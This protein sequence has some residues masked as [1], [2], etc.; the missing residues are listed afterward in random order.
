MFYIKKHV[1]CVQIIRFFNIEQTFD[2]FTLIFWISICYSPRCPECNSI[3]YIHPKFPHLEDEI[4]KMATAER[5]FRIFHTYIHD[6]QNI[7]RQYHDAIHENEEQV[8]I[9]DSDRN[10]DQEIDK[11]RANDAEDVQEAVTICKMKI[12][13]TAKSVQCAS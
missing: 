13:H 5:F 7:L 8:V 1:A 4:Q 6:S 10:G 9:S 12:F 2:S 3:Q 11:V